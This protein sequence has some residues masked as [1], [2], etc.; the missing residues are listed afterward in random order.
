MLLSL[1]LIRS[2]TITSIIAITITIPILI[3]LILTIIRFRTLFPV[4]MKYVT[5]GYVSEKEAGERLAQTVYDDRTKKSGV[6]WSWNGGARA[7]G[8][9]DITKEG[10]LIVRGAGGGGGGELFEN[11]YSKKVRNEADAAKMWDYSTQITSVT[12]PKQ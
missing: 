12:W 6:Y 7:V 5:G 4:F 1:S 10:K 11:E 8:F 9:A 2:N 3:F